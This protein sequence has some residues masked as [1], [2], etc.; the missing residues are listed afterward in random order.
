MLSAFRGSDL[1]LFVYEVVRKPDKPI[2]H[3]AHPR[4]I[5]NWWFGRYGLVLRSIC[6]GVP[7]AAVGAVRGRVHYALA[8]VEDPACREPHP[9]VNPL[10]SS[11]GG[12]Q[13]REFHAPSLFPRAGR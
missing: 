5:E 12:L 10:S 11:P 3:L 8:W 1:P 6:P 2:V 9:S 7:L 13:L 4:V